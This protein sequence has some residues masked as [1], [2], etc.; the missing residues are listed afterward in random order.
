MFPLERGQVTGA[1][2]DAVNS[3]GAGIDNKRRRGGSLTRRMIGIA[4]VWIL[5]QIFRGIY[6]LRADG[7]VQIQRAIGLP[8]TVYLRI[9]A[10]GQGW[11]KIHIMLQNRTMEFEAS[12]P[13]GQL[14]SG[15]QI[16][17]TKILGPD[18]VEVQSLS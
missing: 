7:T 14:S 4:A 8:G 10:Q 5:S 2:P 6:L 3:K 12:T 13:A 17:V 1:A 11:G 15:T 16:V 9:P 18:R